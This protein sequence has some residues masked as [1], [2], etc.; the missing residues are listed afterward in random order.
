MKFLFFLLIILII[1]NLSLAIDLDTIIKIAKEQENIFWKNPEAG[2]IPWNIAVD[3]YTKLLQIYN[4]NQYQEKLIKLHMEG[5]L[6]NKKNPNFFNFHYAYS[7]TYPIKA[8]LLVLKGYPKFDIPFFEKT[9]PLFIT[10]QNQGDKNIDLSKSKFYL[11][12]IG[13]FSESILNNDPRYREILNDSLDSLPLNKTLKPKESISFILLFSNNRPP[14]NLIIEIGDI[15][16]N[17]IFFENILLIE[18][19]PLK[20]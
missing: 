19:L 6:M 15:K 17:I 4:N 16:L 10:L 12:N 5:N 20:G 11:E 3:Y 18:T 7:S 1:F 9:L 13:N 14:K 8:I 2:Y